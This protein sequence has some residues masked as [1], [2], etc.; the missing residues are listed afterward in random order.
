VSHPRIDCVRMPPK[1]AS[2]SAIVCSCF[3]LGFTLVSHVHATPP[4]RRSLMALAL[5]F[6]PQTLSNSP[7]IFS[8]NLQHA[9]S[10]RQSFFHR[11]CSKV[12]LPKVFAAKVFFRTV[13]SF[14][15]TDKFAPAPKSERQL[16]FVKLK[17]PGRK[18]SKSLLK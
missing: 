2:I 14:S 18:K 4:S 8:P 11:L 3:A 16:K 7:I 10:I 13:S 17:T 15:T 6:F 5:Q 9:M 12:H 1:G